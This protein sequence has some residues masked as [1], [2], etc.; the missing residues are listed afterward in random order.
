M[1]APSANGL[2]L[3]TGCL[4]RFRSD[5]RTPLGLPPRW[6]SVGPN[7]APRPDRGAPLYH[8]RA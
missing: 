5:M 8:A 4:L 7:G 1:T 2:Q 3:R 6:F